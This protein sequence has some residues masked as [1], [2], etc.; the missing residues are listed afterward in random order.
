MPGLT[1]ESDTA[2]LN[3]WLKLAYHKP[4]GAASAVVL[5]GLIVVAILAPVIAPYNPY[6]FNLNERGLP[7][8]LQYPNAQF[9]F[10]TD[11]LGRDVL[12]RIIYGSRVSLLV[13]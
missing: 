9:L 11:P 1:P 5:C 2:K 4:L 7:I 13:G 10:G 6:Q 12:S 3:V 8:R